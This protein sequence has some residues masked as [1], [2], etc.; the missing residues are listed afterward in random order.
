MTLKEQYELVK[1]AVENNQLKE[2]FLGAPGYEWGNLKHIPANVATDIGAILE[3]GLYVL[4]NNG[5]KDIPE[6]LKSVVF[7]LLNGMPVEI[8]TAYQIIWNQD[9]DIKHNVAPFCIASPALLERLKQSVTGN[10]KQLSA[11]KELVGWN[12][13]N[14]LWDDIVRLEKN[15]HNKYGKGL[16]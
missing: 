16:I 9:W 6:K 15:M 14:G 10:Q 13:N 11:C 7:D 3:H 12:L 8:W 4:Y 5:S 2:L 1:K